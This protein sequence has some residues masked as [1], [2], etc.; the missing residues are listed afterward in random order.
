V[1]SS[2]GFHVFGMLWNVPVTGQAGVLDGAVF[3]SRP[4]VDRACAR[5]LSAEKRIPALM[6][7][8][9]CGSALT[10]YFQSFIYGVRCAL[11]DAACLR[12]NSAS[13]I[14]LTLEPVSS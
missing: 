5:G 9:Y 4:A 7:V 14:E 2:V 6:W 13:R 1:W 11:S 8:A 3:W 10:A 12:V